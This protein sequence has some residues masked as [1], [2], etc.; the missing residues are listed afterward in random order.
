MNEKNLPLETIASAITK[1][2]WWATYIEYPYYI[3]MPEIGIS[4]GIDEEG[5]GYAW[6]NDSGRR[7][8]VVAFSSSAEEVARG[9]VASFSSLKEAI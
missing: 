6:G 2:T 5:E 7:C 3:Y 1:I 9:F 4:M 8:G